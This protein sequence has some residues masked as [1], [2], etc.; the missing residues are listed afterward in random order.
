MWDAEAG[1]SCED[2]SGDEDED[3]ARREERI[4]RRVRE[5]DVK[6]DEGQGEWDQ[7]GVEEEKK[8]GE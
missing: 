3:M 1:S 2:S 5:A 6:K 8:G 7:K 4:A